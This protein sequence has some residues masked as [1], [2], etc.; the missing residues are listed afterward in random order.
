[1]VREGFQL[2][3][4]AVDLLLR[5][6]QLVLL[7]L[8]HVEPP[9]AHRD[10]HRALLVRAED[11]RR[12][13][14]DLVAVRAHTPDRRRRLGDHRLQIRL[15]RLGVR[16]GEHV[17]VHLVDERHQRLLHPAVELAAQLHGALLHGVCTSEERPQNLVE[18]H[19]LAGAL[20]A[21]EHPRGH[22]LAALL[23]DDRKPVQK[24]VLDFSNADDVV[25]HPL[26]CRES[27]LLIFLSSAHVLSGDEGV[28]HF[29]GFVDH[30]GILRV[31]GKM[32]LRYEGSQGRPVRL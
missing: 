7:V 19:A 25:Q 2:V 11:E 20:R 6:L 15:D 29:C 26:D 30:D 18:E 5:N 16:A 32:P 17:R 12:V 24:V 23:P 27:S 22:G 8:R 4:D 9:V 31:K 1:M 13:V 10:R 3:L 21:R 28:N 14:L